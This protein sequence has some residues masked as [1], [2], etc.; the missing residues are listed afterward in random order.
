MKQPVRRR[1]APPRLPAPRTDLVYGWRTRILTVLENGVTQLRDRK[2]T[3]AKRVQKG[4]QAT[5]AARALL[6]LAPTG[7]KRQARGLVLALGAIRRHLAE[8][9]DTDAL[10]ESLNEIA[11]PA[12]LSEREHRALLRPLQARRV[13]MQ[14]LQ[15]NETGEAIEMMK[16]VMAQIAGWSLPR[17]RNAMIVAAIAD[18]YRRLRR[19]CAPEL[20]RLD[21]EDLH[22]L[23][24]RAITHR[25]QMAFIAAMAPEARRDK[26]E[27]QV[28]RARALHELIGNHRDLHLLAEY[29]R[30]LDSPKTYSLRER[31]LT[32]IVRQKARKVAEAGRL[33]RKLTCASVKRIARRVSP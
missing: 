16:K 26:L 27:R 7:L 33:A 22:D 20:E 23:R 4:R 3:P 9:R 12:K 8:T 18:D 15:S 28:E 25:H 11:G 19:D 6:R 14:R 5:K 30:G 17:R 29:L 31:I 24:K 1:T 21:I 13:P 10:I 32:E 2:L